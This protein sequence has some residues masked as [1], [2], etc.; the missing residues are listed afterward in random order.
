[1][2]HTT[3]PAKALIS[4]A[5]HFGLS[6]LVHPVW[7][8]E[9]PPDNRRPVLPGISCIITSRSPGIQVTPTIMAVRVVRTQ[10]FAGRKTPV[11]AKTPPQQFTQ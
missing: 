4:E 6:D 7:S 1:M 2:A 9:P 8:K 10:Q 3:S 11:G 5:A